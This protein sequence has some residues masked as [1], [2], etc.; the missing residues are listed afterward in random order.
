MVLLF[1]GSV[2]GF[3][4]LMIGLLGVGLSATGG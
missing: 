3:T 1:V 2:I 4:A